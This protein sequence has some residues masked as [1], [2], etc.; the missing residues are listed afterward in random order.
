[1]PTRPSAVK[2]EDYQPPLDIVV[3]GCGLSPVLFLDCPHLDI[4]E[5]CADMDALGFAVWLT[6]STLYI[7]TGDAE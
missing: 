2:R 3:I 4:L 7:F 6:P 5:F 1:M